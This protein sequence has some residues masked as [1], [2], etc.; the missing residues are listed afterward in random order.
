MRNITE[1]RWIESALWRVGER[2]HINL[3]LS[4]H[5]RPKARQTGLSFGLVFVTVVL[6]RWLLVFGV[7][8]AVAAFGGKGRV[9]SF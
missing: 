5:Q 9:F 4:S 7:V 2:E 3:D 8:F 6:G 1:V